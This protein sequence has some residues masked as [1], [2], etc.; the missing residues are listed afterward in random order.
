MAK[1]DANLAKEEQLNQNYRNQSFYW[2]VEFKFKNLEKGAIHII[3]PWKLRLWYV[4]KFSVILGRELKSETPSTRI[5]LWYLVEKCLVSAWVILDI[6][7][8]GN[9]NFNKLNLKSQDRNLKKGF[10]LHYKT[11]PWKLLMWLKM[12]P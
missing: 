7:F 12:Y 3:L 10:K 2:K 9:L 8:E 5:E 1:C 4:L 11:L 6:R